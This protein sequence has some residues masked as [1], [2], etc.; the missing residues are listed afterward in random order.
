MISAELLTKIEAFKDFDAEKLNSIVENLNN[1]VV[2]TIKAEKETATKEA[3]KTFISELEAF[4][5]VKPAENDK[6]PDYLSKVVKTQNEKLIT[7]HK[8]EIEKIRLS[9]TSDQSKANETLNAVQKEKDMLV[10]NYEKQIAEQKQNLEFFK[11]KTAILKQEPKYK[12]NAAKDLAKHELNNIIDVIIK[13]NMDKY[14]AE[15]NLVG[16]T[17]ENKPEWGYNP[18]KNLEDLIFKASPSIATFIDSPKN[19]SGNGSQSDNAKT[20]EI[21]IDVQAE[22]QLAA[23]GLKPT[24]ARFW[25]E[26]RKIITSLLSKQNN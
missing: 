22:R 1:V 12:T 23:K 6:L 21:P 9:L 13:N 17:P 15:G 2:P 16:F 8:S 4:S 11:R 18:F 14:D 19:Q 26:K 5:G 3:Y 20:T 25:E 7:D 10:E 24:D